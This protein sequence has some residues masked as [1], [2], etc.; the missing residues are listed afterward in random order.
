MLTVQGVRGHISAQMVE[1]GVAPTPL[2]DLPLPWLV[3]TTD[4]TQWPNQAEMLIAL[5]QRIT[6]EVLDAMQSLKDSQAIYLTLDKLDVLIASKENPSSAP[7]RLGL[8]NGIRLA[9]SNDLQTG[10]IISARL[11]ITL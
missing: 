6:G 9:R 1:N 2:S 7:T 4:V 3:D 11:A 5:N 8:W 10:R